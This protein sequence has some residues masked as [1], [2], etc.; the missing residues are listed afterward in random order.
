MNLKSVNLGEKRSSN[1]IFEERIEEIDNELRRFD[2][3]INIA[4]KNIVDTGK[5]NMLESLS[6]TDKQPVGT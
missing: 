4:T 1:E 2:P 3:K 5:E 6:I